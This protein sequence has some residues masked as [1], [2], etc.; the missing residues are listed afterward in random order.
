VIK[1]YV[2]VVPRQGGT[3]TRKE[4]GSVEEMLADV[5]KQLVEAKEGWCYPFID[6]LPCQISDPVQVFK[7]KAPDGKEYVI[8]NQPS[9]FNTENFFRVLLPY[10]RQGGE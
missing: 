9:A 10:E 3:P 5:F 4:Y 2:V 6:G 8:G 1:P 7:L